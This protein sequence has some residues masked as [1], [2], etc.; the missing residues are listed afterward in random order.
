MA[1]I[2]QVQNFNKPLEDSMGF[3]AIVHANGLLHLAG[4]AI[5]VMHR[6]PSGRM[7]LRAL[8]AAVAVGG[9]FFLWR[10]VK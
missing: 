4:I 1:K 7:A 9:L 2:G 5:G 3:S 8:G 6:W 10:A